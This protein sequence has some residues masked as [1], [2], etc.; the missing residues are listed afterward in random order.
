MS[1]ASFFNGDVSQKLLVTLGRRFASA[2]KKSCKPAHIFL[3][4]VGQREKGRR[5]KYSQLTSFL[6]HLLK[7]CQSQ[8]DYS[9]HMIKR[10]SS[11]INLE[12]AAVDGAALVGKCEC[13]V[14]ARIEEAIEQ[15]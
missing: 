13:T 1:E 11:I 12:M 14:E 3:G 15:R 8:S 10:L 4:R 5:E 6:R 7:C 9:S 2:K